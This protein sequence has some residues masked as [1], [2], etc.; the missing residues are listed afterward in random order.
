LFGGT[1]LVVAGTVV[2]LIIWATMPPTPPSPNPYKLMVL[3]DGVFVGNPFAPKTID[4]FDEPIC[5]D[6]SKFVTASASDIHNAVR[7]DKIAVRYHVLNFEDKQSASGDY[8]TR[9]VA[10]TYCVADA[11]DPDLYQ[12]FYAA[13]FAPGFQPARGARTDRT[14]SELA[15]LAQKAGAGEGVQSCIRSGQKLSTATTKAANARASFR[16]LSSDLNTPE[17]FDGNTQVNITNQGWV[18]SLS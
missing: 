14:D 12:A 18:D 16:R 5:P 17:V 6:C 8:S 2:G 13:I 15:Q 7:A 9:A 1:G 11:N 3:D 4:V 10:A